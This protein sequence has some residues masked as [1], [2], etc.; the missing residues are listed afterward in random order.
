MKKYALIIHGG[1]GAVDKFSALEQKNFLKSL[2]VILA[3]G[4]LMLKEGSPALDVAEACVKM[5]EDDPIYNAGKGSV[6]NENGEVEMDASIMDGR[7]LKAGAV[8]G[9]FSAKNPI[10]VARRVMEKTAHVM[11]IGKGAEKFI[12]KQGLEQKPKTYFVT[13]HRVVQL[14]KAQKTAAVSLDHG[15]ARSKAHLKTGK[16]GTVGAV[17]Y[18]KFGNIA[19]A[20]STGGMTNKMVGR[21]GDSPLIGC[22]TYADNLTCGVS[23]TGRGEDFIRTGLAKFV[24]DLIAIK[25]WKA[26][27]AAK[28]A[29]NYFQQRVAGYGGFIM[30]DRAGRV[31]DA[32]STEGLIRAYVQEGK[33]PVCKLFN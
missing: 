26:P 24:S 16:L 25:K 29:I 33:K 19:A 28:F 2:E 17:A 13:K 32:Y 15:S 14:K 20:T 31:A 10:E 9:L 12:K 5:L 8:A 6:L 21:T 3:K 27:K 23:C 22:G 18:D 11:L 4:E 1:C 7:N 30:I